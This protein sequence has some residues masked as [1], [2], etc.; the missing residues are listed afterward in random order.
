[1]LGFNQKEILLMAADVFFHRRGTPGRKGRETAGLDD[2]SIETVKVHS[3]L[4]RIA[5]SLDRSHAGL[6]AHARLKMGEKNT[7]SLE[8]VCDKGCDLEMWGAQNHREVFFKA[9]GKKLIIR[10]FEQ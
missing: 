10:Q 9:F 6:I 5:E 3:V 4:L 7:V 8:I 2:R 1:M